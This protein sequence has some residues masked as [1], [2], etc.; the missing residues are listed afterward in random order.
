MNN[1]TRSSSINGTGA[2]SYYDALATAAGGASAFRGIDDRNTVTST[3]GAPITVY[4]VP[5]TTGK[6]RITVTLVGRAGTVTSAIYTFKYTVAATVI[7]DTV[8]I[9]AVDT[10]ASKSI[11]VLPDLSTNITGQLTT[12]TGASASVDITCLVEAVGAGT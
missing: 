8:S 2:I 6:F 9:S 5:A 7:T 12:L 4:A 1:L 10:D 11:I 3:D